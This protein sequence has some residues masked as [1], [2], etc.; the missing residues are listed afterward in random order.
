MKGGSRRCLF[1][2]L[3]GECRCLQRALAG[4]AG[5]AFLPYLAASRRV[6]R[7]L[8]VNVSCRCLGGGERKGRR[9]DGAGLRSLGQPPKQG[10]VKR[11]AKSTMHDLRLISETEHRSRSGAAVSGYAKRRRMIF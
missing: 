1:V 6:S 7:V 2:A 10:Q 3:R 11:S 5:S 9:Y 4:A 8:F